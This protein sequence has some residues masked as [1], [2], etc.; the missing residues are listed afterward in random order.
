V[1]PD[2]TKFFL[3]FASGDDWRT[4]LWNLT[5]VADISRALFEARSRDPLK[6]GAVDV[7][8]AYVEALFHGCLK[9][10]Q[11]RWKLRQQRGD[12]TPAE[13]AQRVTTNLAHRQST[14]MHNSRKHQVKCRLVS[15]RSESHICTET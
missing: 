13:T 10:S 1:R 9:R 6:F 11:E 15:S 5:T 3:D 7:S 12:E 2:P 4:S 8:S 14:T